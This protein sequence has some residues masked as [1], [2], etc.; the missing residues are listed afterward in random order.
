M[1]EPD[2]TDHHR[3][4]KPPTPYSVTRLFNEETTVEREII[5][6][7]QTPALGWTYR[8][9]QQV[10]ALRPD[11]REV[12]LLQLLREKLKQLNPTILTDEARVDAIVTKLRA[13]RD[14]QQWLAW[15]QNGINYQFDP[16]EKAKDVRLIAY[17]DLTLND[18]WL[19]NQFPVE[20]NSPRRPDIVLLINGILV[21]V[22]EAKTASRSKP[23]W[24]LYGS[25]LDA[26]FK[27]EFGHLSQAER[28]KLV[29]QSSTLDVLLKLPKRIEQIAD[30]VTVHFNEHVR[31][32]GFKAML[33]CKDKETV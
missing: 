31:P 8:S 11:E 20:G 10:M 19:T 24:Q 30:D 16:S 15:L 9:R 2:F 25:K 13:C 32:N 17:D 29:S 33:V 21:V 3:I 18:W 7:L 4:E 23:D 27:R 26:A 12:L 5:Q 14:N 22:I 6:H 28:N 1:T